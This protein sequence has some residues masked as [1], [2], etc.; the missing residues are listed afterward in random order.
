MNYR[1]FIEL[2]YNGKPFHGWQIQDN[3]LTVQE[4]LND[5]LTTI[6]REK[7]NVVGAGRTDTGVHASYFMAHF[8]LGV[9]IN[10][11]ELVINK[12]NKFLPR[13]I[14]VYDMK[15]VKNDAHTRFNALSRTYEYRIN[16]IKNPFL[17]DFAWYY[18]V[19][20]NIGKMN[21]AAELLFEFEDFTSFSKTGTQVATNNCKVTSAKWFI[22]NDL[23]IFK[24]RADRFLRNMVRAIVGTLIDVGLE[25]IKKEDFRRIIEL[26][27]RNHAGLSVPAHGLYLTD[28]EY[29]KDLFIDN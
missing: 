6:L 27:D 4:V 7:I 11:I 14:V 26:K 18:K 5:S 16:S 2:G 13:E 15:R 17:T 1:Y 10:D 22:N 8:D 28:I 19:P 9:A 3:A 23:I 29:P 24:I 12:L 20:L 21:E 25:K